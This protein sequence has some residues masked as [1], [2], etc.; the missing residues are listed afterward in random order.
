MAGVTALLFAARTV[1]AF[2]LLPRRRIKVL[3][4]S[5]RLFAELFPEALEIEPSVGLIGYGLSRPHRVLSCVAF[6]SKDTGSS[7]GTTYV[8]VPHQ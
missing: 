7:V 6:G 8:K 3:W 5:R 1:R 2:F 4:L